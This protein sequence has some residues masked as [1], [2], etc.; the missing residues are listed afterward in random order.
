MGWTPIS[1]LG[2]MGRTVADVCLLCAAQIGQHEWIRCRIPLDPTAF[3]EPRPVDLGSL[4]VA[5][6]ED[7]GGAPVE[8]GIRQVLPRQ[9]RGDEASVPV[10]ATRW[11]SI[12]GADRCFDV[13]RAVNF[14]RDISDAYEQ[15][16]ASTLGPNIVANYEIGAKM[17]LGRL[18]LGT[19]RSRRGF[20]ARFQQIFTRLRPGDRRRRRLY[21]RSRGSSSISREMDGKQLSNYYHWLATDVLHHARPPIPAIV[22][23]V[24]RRPQEDAVRPAGGRPFPRR[25]RGA[26][27]R[28][29]D[30][31]GIRG[32][33]RH[34]RRPLPDLN[35]LSNPR[36]R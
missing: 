17:T 22:A 9:D 6:T 16:S 1:V 13:I 14:R 24:R 34:S 33:R 5:Y 8:K 23:A 7:F 36:R 27:R 35:K 15:G 32:H 28:A 29:R 18:R 30:G 12:G 19:R 2:P 3:A 25:W 26:G 20:S 31:A 4:R 11:R 10:A 21:R